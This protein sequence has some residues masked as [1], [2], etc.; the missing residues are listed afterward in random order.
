M[1][2][3]EQKIGQYLEEAHATE[4]ALI[5]VLQSQ[6]A[7][8][9]RGSTRT[10]IEEHLEETRDHADRVRARA[11]ALQTKTRGNPLQAWVG[12]T[13]AVVGQ[14]IALGKTPLDLVRGTSAEEKVLKHAKDDCATEALEI[15]TYTAIERLAEQHGDRE[16]A[17][18]A[19]DILAD[20]RRMLDR[21]LGEEIPKLTDAV[22]RAELRGQPSFDPT[23]TGAAEAVGAGRTDDEPPFAGYDDLTASE[24]VER[25]PALSQDQLAAVAG[26]E[27]AH[28]ARSTV[29]ERVDALAGDE[30]WDGYDGQGVT[31]IRAALRDADDDTVARVREYERRHKARAGVLDAAERTAAAKA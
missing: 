4:M 15:A 23:T 1:S 2:S 6:I 8:T 29:L 25:L 19:A 31:D 16:T 24:V 12:L 21:L 10:A 7:M 5:R 17:R 13:E 26:Y 14:A 9:P 18:L 27:R 3:Y 28:E 20:E 11:N 30:P 22:A